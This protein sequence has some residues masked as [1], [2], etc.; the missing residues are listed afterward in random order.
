MVALAL[1]VLV[2]VLAAGSVVYFGGPSEDY[3]ATYAGAYAYMMNYSGSS[4]N[5]AHA[6]AEQIDAGFPSP[7]AD[8]YAREIDAGKSPTYARAYAYADEL[9]GRYSG[10]QKAYARAYAEQI[11]AGH[12]HWYADAYA[13]QVGDSKSPTY[14]RT[15]AELVEA[16]KSPAYHAHTDTYAHAYARE[17]EAGKSP[18][19]VRA[20]TYARFVY[21]LNEERSREIAEEVNPAPALTPPTLS[22]IDAAAVLAMYSATDDT[23]A[24]RRATSVREITTYLGRGDMDNDTA[25]GL[26]SDIAPGASID[27]RVEAASRLASISDNSDGELTSEQTMEVAN[28]LTRLI[29]GHGIDAEQRAG[30]A[31]E[32]VRLSQSGELNADNAAELMDTIAPEWSVTERKEAL[33]YLAL[34]FSEG[35][36]DADSAKRTAEE[37][38]TLITGGEIQMERRMEASI[39][40]AGEGLKRYGGDSYDDE[41]VD[42]AVALTQE[43]IRGDLTTDSVSNILGLDAGKS[44][45][46]T[47]DSDAYVNTDAYKRKYSEIRRIETCSKSAFWA[48]VGMDVKTCDRRYSRSYAHARASVYAGQIVAGKSEEYADRYSRQISG[49]KSGKYAAAYARQYDAGR[50]AFNFA[51]TYARL[52]DAGKSEEYAYFVAIFVSELYGTPCSKVDR[53]TLGVCREH[54]Q[55]KDE[56]EYVRIYVKQ[57]D[58]GKSAGQ[59]R[60]YVE[61]RIGAGRSEEFAHAYTEQIGAGKPERYAHAY[62]HARVNQ[63]KDIGYA[64]A[65]AQAYTLEFDYDDW[66]WYADDYDY[67]NRSGW[68]ARVY[69]EQI[70]ASKSSGYARIYARQIVAGKPKPYAHAYTEQIVAGKSQAYANIYASIASTGLIR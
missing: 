35:E 69:A 20:Y 43:A 65:Y 21:G 28:E 1:L 41:G 68:Y 45:S 10:R 16:G 55:D 6:Y 54:W 53:R 64:R 15:Y 8:A 24:D 59:A 42:Q 29:T 52:Y 62:A 34:Q 19:Y 30:A 22:P 3:Q 2:V 9:Y 17:I 61:Q 4:A 40:L 48:S 32:M 57:F 50:G 26:L 27:D 36:W 33:G 60:T 66:N 39:E 51:A 44:S 49:G 46:N 12:L 37:G 11:D 13:E 14:G 47:S 70:V 63:Q 56:T 23:E 5:Y 18:T 58:A 31:R 25:L 67:A 38:Y 7:Y